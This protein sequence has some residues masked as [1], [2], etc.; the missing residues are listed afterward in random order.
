MKSIP[1]LTKIKKIL[2][3]MFMSKHHMIN[4]SHHSLIENKYN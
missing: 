4:T 3:A 2:I 1:K